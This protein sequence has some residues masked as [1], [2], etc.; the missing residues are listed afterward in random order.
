MAK[1]VALMCG[2]G[3]SVDGSWDPGCA[4][5]KYTEAALMLP[6][7]K[8]AVK[9]LR[10]Y[11]V[12]VISDA[13]S[14]NNKNMIADVRWANQ[15]KTDI[16]VSVH[17]DYSKAPSGVMPLYTSKGG[18]K[19]ASCLN[20]AVKS[21][22]SMKSRG[23][24]KRNDLWELNGTDMVACI[25]ETGAI[26]ADLSTLKNKSDIYGK[27]I[28]KGI[29][30]YLGVQA[31]PYAEGSV[32]TAP[33]K[34]EKPANLYR[35]RK[36]WADAK[37]Q[38]GAFKDLENA[39]TSADVNHMNVYDSKGKLVYS[40]SPAPKVKD[41]STLVAEKA[42]EYCYA[43]TDDKKELAKT[44]YPHGKPKASYKKALDSLPYSKHKWDPGA[45]SGANCDVFVWTCVVKSGVDKNYPS[46]LWKQLNYML[47]HG[48]QQ[49]DPS[50]A[51][52]GDI[53]FYIK[54]TKKK[55]GHIGIVYSNGMVKEASHESY[56]PRTNKALKSRLSKTGKKKV[57]VFRP[58]K[59][60]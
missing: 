56:Y 24:I 39:K 60:K 55:K 57:Y 9:Y 58:K 52:P 42:N 6:I 46:G 7:T 49:V 40:G 54:K 17:C 36:S 32:T 1:K 13:D 22:M 33:A 12:T 53:Y 29:C 4:Y 34:P 27:C 8:A 59:A 16:Y 14:N 5:G 41:A 21:G 3:K 20:S 45:R 38:V 37:S 31:K 28:A 43:Y 2:H 19:L 30:D 47:D 25:L 26:K 11:G 48:W 10:A 18:K 15:Q 51:K 44:K 50:K 35:V 23:V